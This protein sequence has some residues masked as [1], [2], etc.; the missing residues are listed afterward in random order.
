MMLVTLWKSGS[1]ILW[2]DA[3]F[4]LGTMKLFNNELFI[5]Y[6]WTIHFL[7]VIF[8]IST[9]DIFVYMS[10]HFKSI[11]KVYKTCFVPDQNKFD[12]QWNK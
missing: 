1:A 2:V 7:Y 12:R 4:F 10:K 8:D 3:I 11:K 5:R 9:V 6:F